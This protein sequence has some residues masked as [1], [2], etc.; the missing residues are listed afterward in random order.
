MVDPTTG[1]AQ[2]CFVTEDGFMLCNFIWRKGVAAWTKSGK[3]WK[4]PARFR[5]RKKKATDTIV[6]APVPQPVP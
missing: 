6:V 3:W 4:F 1:V 5:R 2:M